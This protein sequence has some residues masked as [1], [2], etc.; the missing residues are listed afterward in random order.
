MR[1]IFVL[2][3]L[4]CGPQG[5]AA[6]TYEQW[7]AEAARIIDRFETKKLDHVAD[8]FDCQGLSLGAQQKPIVNGGLADL[9]AAINRDSRAVSFDVARKVAQDTMPRF[10]EPFIQ[11]LNLT[12]DSKFP[13]ARVAAL[14]LQN[15]TQ[16]DLCFGGQ[17]GA[18][19]KSGAKEELTAWLQSDP[20]VAAQ[21]VL[22]NR[23]ASRALQAAF[24]WHQTYAEGTSLE[25]RVFVYH[26]DF[27]TNAGPLGIDGGEY[28]R[29]SDL[30]RAHDRYGFDKDQRM[31][32]KAEN[33]ARW[34][35]TEWVDPISTQ[36]EA[37]ARRNAA[38][39]RSGE[40][41]LG[42]DELQLL[43]VRMMRA[44]LGSTPAQ[45]SFFNRGFLLVNGMG[46]F[47]SAQ[48]D[49][50]DRYDRMGALSSAETET[51]RCE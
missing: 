18:G 7:L 34:M 1:L 27:L 17:T 38:L 10:S 16:S 20:L 29:V 32:R 42:Y 45:M 33:L 24:C 9:V 39:L 15:V 6:A 22:K 46:W 19:F 13:E 26:L 4:I 21:A 5:G 25:F 3:L 8:D 36:H 23:D 30:I 44:Q 31:A 49:L 28:Y 48:T 37:D 43:Y 50:R 2:A 12:E 11:V 40:V 51:I 41:Q 35:E 47:Q 14:Q